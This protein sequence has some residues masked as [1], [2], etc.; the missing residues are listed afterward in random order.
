[1]NG[2]LFMKRRS[3]YKRISLFIK[4]L[5]WFMNEKSSCLDRNIAKQVWCF[6]FIQVRIHANNKNTCFS[7]ENL[8]IS[9]WIYR[10]I[11][12]LHHQFHIIN[13]H[14]NSAT[15]ESKKQNEFI[16]K[17]LAV[18]KIFN[19]NKKR[20]KKEFVINFQKKSKIKRKVF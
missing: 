20:M 19:K 5:G 8:R 3:I 12:F 2:R 10:I 7:F 14:M 9:I 6:V 13:I 4:Q 1:M 11:K 16:M 15:F 18:T 17:I